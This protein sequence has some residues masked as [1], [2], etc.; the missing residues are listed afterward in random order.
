MHLVFTVP[1]PVL[2]NKQLL[3]DLLFRASA[4]TLLEGVADPKHRGAEIGF[5][6][7]EFA[8][9]QLPAGRAKALAA[10]VTPRP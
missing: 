1:Q 4:E 5:L 7:E 2:Q 6:V 3:Y 9:A 8:G 10:A